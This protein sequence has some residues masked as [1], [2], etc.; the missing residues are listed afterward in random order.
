MESF[1]RQ[2]SVLAKARFPILYVETY[3]ERR[4]LDDIIATVG[5]NGRL[6]APRPVH[7]WSRTAGLRNPEGEVIRN[8][9][10]PLQALDTIQRIQESS[11][12]VMLD[13]HAHLGDEHRP[14]DP[15]IVRK[16]REIAADFQYLDVKR[17]LIIVAPMLRI[18]TELEKD[19]HI[20]DYPLPGEGAIRA[21]LD[22]L[23][24]DNAG[25]GGIV[26]SLTEEEKDRLVRAAIGLTETE[27]ESALAMAMAE[28]GILDASDIDTVLQEKKQA[29]RKSGLLEFIDADVDLGSVGGLDNLKRWLAR[30]DGS[31]LAEAQEFGIAA[32]RGVLMTGLPGCGKSLTAKAV[33]ATWHLPLLRLDIG[34][35]F[36][37]LVGSS[38]QNLRSAIRAAEAAAPAVLWVDEIEKGFSGL[39]GSGD[40]GTSSRVFGTFLTWMQEKTAPV[41]VIATSNNV[42]ALPPELLRKGRFDEIFFV[43]LPGDEERTQIWNLQIARHVQ[44]T[45]RNLDFV[46][47]SK[48]LAE[49]TD[50]T[51][52]FSG[53]E[54]EQAVI[55]A[56]FDA[57]ADR[58]SVAPSD[59]IAAVQRTVPLSITQA[60]QLSTIRAWASSRA[61]SASESNMVA[62]E[63]LS[64]TT[65]PV[66][67]TTSATPGGR[68]VDF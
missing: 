6:S 24:H 15:A 25:P 41:F 47:H 21:I 29:V 37:G 58:R 53:A 45:P 44:R 50:A 18:P 5:P 17:T 4:V 49:L 1:K 28:D 33:A 51:D 19:I 11:T 35:V 34:K 54:I 55:A 8:T 23:I 13:L 10:E 22:G 32:P 61:V 40:S 56:L 65:P 12:F 57:F 43:D 59:L 48:R 66:P 38:E 68:R 31:W 16:L 26:V 20:L 9:E 7:T 39:S 63:P 46:L 42:Q 62:A 3:E 67:P 52:G 64:A 30:R 27:A 36:S 60:E 14:A 2:L